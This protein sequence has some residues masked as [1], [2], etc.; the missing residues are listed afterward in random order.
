MD[1]EFKNYV[2]DNFDFLVKLYNRYIKYSLRNSSPVEYYAS[3][4]MN[5]VGYPS[6]KFMVFCTKYYNKKYN[7]SLKINIT[8]ERKIINLYLYLKLVFFFILSPLI[9][10]KKIKKNSIIIHSFHTDDNFK[11][12]P[13]KTIKSPPLEYFKNKNIYH[14]INI[15]FI[16]LKSLLKYKKSN[17]VCSLNHLSL[18]EFSSLHYKAFIIYLQSRKINLFPISYVDIMYILIKGVA[19]SKLINSLD[20]ESKYLHMFEKRGYHLIA[21]FLVYNHEKSIF[22]D[23]GIAFRM[24]PEYMMFNYTKHTLKSRFMFMSNFNYNLLKNNL[25]NIKYKLFKNYRIDCE[26]YNSKGKKNSILLI[27]PLSLSVANKLY[28]LIIDNK[29]LNIKIRLHPYLNKKNF[30]IKYIEQ[31]GIYESLDDYDTIVYSGVTTAAIELY[32]QGKKTYK[33]IS[34]EF[35]DLDPLVDNNLVKKIKFL[36]QIKNDTATFSMKEKDY[37][38]GCGNRNLKQVLEELK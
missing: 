35:L 13:Y 25:Q 16:S 36:E 20:R 29:N 7:K 3:P 38:L 31:R 22:L 33:F 34:D 21:D 5:L 27:S 1:R 37:Y 18:I 32:F 8:K 2:E 24:S 26:N 11:S 4:Y 28:Q 17:I 30:E 19:T 6:D 15:S 10:N 9:F 14:D 12:T 23:L